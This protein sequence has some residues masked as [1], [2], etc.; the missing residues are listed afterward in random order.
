[1]KNRVIDE[2]KQHFR[3]EFLNRVDDTIVFPQ[4]TQD[5]I[6]E[7]VDLMLAKLDERL[8]DKDMGIELTPA[9]KVLLATKGYDPVLG[10]RPLRRT[11]QRDI[12]DVLSEKILYGELK[13]GSI[14]LVDTDGAEKDAQFTFVGSPKATI[15]DV[16]DGRGR[17]QPV[18]RPRPAG[19]GAGSASKPQHGV[20]TDATHDEGPGR[21]VAPGPSAASALPDATAR[22]M[23]RRCINAWRRGRAT[24]QPPGRARR[25][26]HRR[27]SRR[28]RPGRRRLRTGS[29]SARCRSGCANRLVVVLVGRASDRLAMTTRWPAFSPDSDLR[30]GRADGSGPDQRAG[31][32]AVGHRLDERRCRSTSVVDGRVRHGEHV[33]D[34]RQG[35][36]RGRGRPAGQGRGGRRHPDHDRVR[37]RVEVLEAGSRLI[38]RT[39]AGHRRWTTRPPSRVAAW[40]T[41]TLRQRRER[42]VDRD[43]DRARRRRW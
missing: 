4:L 10:A 15:P 13:P 17:R 26:R 14:V 3:P 19:A 39:V 43:V 36:R 5:E 7:I 9:A 6:I 24:A 1:M 11:I 25:S 32:L 30:R 34:R 29:R 28:R 38:E 41:L 31:H 33:L 37:H 12:E 8:R 40:P 20:S 42:Y 21:T 2:L 35:D 23:T 22:R 27:R 18:A 16:A